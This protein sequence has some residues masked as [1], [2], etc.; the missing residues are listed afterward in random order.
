MS[1]SENREPL[2]DPD[3]EVWRIAMVAAPLLASGRFDRPSAVAEAVRL[4]WEAHR[5]V[6]DSIEVRTMF[7]IKNPYP[8]GRTLKEVLGDLGLKERQ[9]KHW[10]KRARPDECEA[11][12]NVAKMGKNAFENDVVKDI[13]RMRTAAFRA[14]SSRRHLRPVKG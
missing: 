1:L 4:F 9:L 10:L 5:F 6:Y 3:P 12:W 14:R 7:R 13:D 8:T 2:L 11:I